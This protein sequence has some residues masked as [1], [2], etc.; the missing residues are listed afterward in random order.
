MSEQPAEGSGPRFDDLG[1]MVKRGFVTG[2]V[3]IAPLAVTVFVIQLVYGWLVGAIRPVLQALP[4]LRGPYTEPLA[5][6]ALFAL[7]T[8][9][10]IVFLYGFGDRLM[11]RFD[12]FMQDVPGISPIYRSVRQATTALT[13][14]TES[15]EQVVLVHL[16]Q[17]GLRVVGFVTAETPAS[18]RG[19]DIDEPCYN[20]FVPMAP[21]PMGG[22]LIVV[23][24]ADVTKT[25]LTVSEGIQ[26]VLTTGIG[27]QDEDEVATA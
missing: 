21:N 13:G 19:E 8:V 3:L 24:E 6:V 4:W 26:L 27:G 23:P 2:L 12:N 9:G 7:I 15:F 18:L 17:S 11:R 10:G 20:V 16:P 1:S 14:D 5:L 25:D 22:F